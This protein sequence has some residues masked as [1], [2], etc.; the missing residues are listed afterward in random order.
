MSPNPFFIALKF[1][2]V[3]H[4][5]FFF[6]VICDCTLF[7]FKSFIDYIQGG[8]F[9]HLSIILFMIVRS[10]GGVKF[11]PELHAFAL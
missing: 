3:G 9:S 1:C 11:I 4:V 6:Q 10:C 8:I 2:S 7:T 5:V